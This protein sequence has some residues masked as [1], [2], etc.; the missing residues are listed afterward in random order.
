M[1]GYHNPVI[2]HDNLG[3]LSN[4]HF[5]KTFRLGS[6]YRSEAAPIFVKQINIFENIGLDNGLLPVRH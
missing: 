4:D 2:N 5:A 6:S 1:Q 3:I